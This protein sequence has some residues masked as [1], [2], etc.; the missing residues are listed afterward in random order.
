MAKPVKPVPSLEPPSKAEQVA[1]GTAKAR[2]RDRSP[3]FAIKL[4]EGKKAQTIN[5]D[6]SDI[7]GWGARLQDA[8]GTKGTSFA[9][10]ELNRLI[11]ASKLA[12]GTIDSAR[13]NGYI[14]SIDGLKPSTELEAMIACQLAVT[15]SLSMELVQRTKNAK[16]IPQFDAAGNMAAKMLRAFAMQ[17]E[18]LTKL[19][20]GGEQT[21][22]VEHVHVHSGGQAIVG[23]V[24]SGGGGRK[25][26][27]TNPMHPSTEFKTIKLARRDPS[28]L[29]QA[30]RCQASTRKRTPCQSPAV[31]GK[32]RCR[33]H[34]GALG[35]GAPRGEAN[36]AYKH[37]E[38]TREARERR[39][40]LFGWIR[41]LR[42]TAK[43]VADD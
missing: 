11:T 6:H 23:N 9:A 24:T 18:T 16:E 7:V 1:I 43:T 2:V 37:G 13:L 29:C 31:K 33:M 38:R 35:S 20:R 39:K 8:F 17:V 12:D 41:V 22:R 32:A 19:K 40:E 28:R 26:R 5:P 21:V 10:V 36:G 14:A 30:K 3:R 27:S 42:G 25:K 15:H 34:G 4:D